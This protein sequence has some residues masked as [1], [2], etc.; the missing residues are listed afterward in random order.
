MASSQREICLLLWTPRAREL[1]VLSKEKKAAFSRGRLEL[2]RHARCRYE[3]ISVW[4]EPAQPALQLR[5]RSRA[6]AQQAWQLPA[7][8]A[9][10]QLRPIARCRPRQHSW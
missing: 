5:C 7:R 3:T 8:S 2:I 10:G 1:E 9:L 4:S 6:S